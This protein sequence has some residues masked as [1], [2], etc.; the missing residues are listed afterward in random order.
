MV[1]DP[2]LWLEDIDGDSALSWVRE[3]NDTCV[4]AFSG[5]EFERMRTEALEVLD[6]KAR[7]SHTCADSTFKCPTCG[8]KPRSPAA[9]RLDGCRRPPSQRA[10]SA[11]EP[12]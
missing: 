9:Q 3:R 2:Y 1:A 10:R 4:T 8:N 11:R 5:A 6:M 7:Q 12:G